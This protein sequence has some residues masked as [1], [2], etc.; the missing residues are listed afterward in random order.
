M[1]KNIF[2]LASLFLA[3][4]VPAANATAAADFSRGSFR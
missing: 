4:T 3:A 2:L 1:K